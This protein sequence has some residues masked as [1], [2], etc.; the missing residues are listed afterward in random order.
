[1][2]PPVLDDELGEIPEAGEPD[3][4]YGRPNDDIH[5]PPVGGEEPTTQGDTRGN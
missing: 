5:R 3:G 2:T 1:M 4:G